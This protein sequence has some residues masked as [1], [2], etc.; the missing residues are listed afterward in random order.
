MAQLKSAIGGIPVQQAMVSD[1]KTLHISDSLNRAV[2]LTLAGSQKDFPVM[3]NGH[4]KGILTQADLLKALAESK[5]HPTVAS[6][7]QTDY[8]V[9]DYAD[10]LETAFAKLND[11]QCHTLPV[12]HNER[13]VGLMTM[14][15]LGEY[16]RFQAALSN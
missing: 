7:I 9:V 10:M 11:C 1:F 4:L 16:M 3:D 15:N 6:A 2:E 5:K 13:I 14:D 8:N 12:V